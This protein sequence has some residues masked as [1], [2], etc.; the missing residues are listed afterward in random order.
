MQRLIFSTIIFTTIFSSCENNPTGETRVFSDSVME[1]RNTEVARDKIVE[2]E[3]GIQ[4]KGGLK[5]YP[6]TT[7][8]EF[9]DA[10]LEQNLPEE[11]TKL[12]PG[13][14][15]FNYDVKNYQL[16]DT[17][18]LPAMCGACSNSS[19][20]QHI[21]L[22]LNNNP[23]IAH[24]T[25]EFTENL[26]AGNYVAL[27]F[28]SRSY[29]ESIKSPDAYTLRQFTVGNPKD[30]GKVDLNAPHLFYSRPKGEYAGKEAE[31]ILLDFYLV[32]TDL[33]NTGKKVRATINGNEFIIDKWQP[34]II[35]GLPAGEAT[36]KLELLQ[37]DGTLVESPFNPVTRTITVKKEQATS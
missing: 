17:T 28:L 10:K 33:Q 3:L 35:E 20:G 8:P 34:Y 5:L 16:Q 32:N 29:H 9:S 26:K 31:K 19:K 13:E 22:I 37:E 21:H 11:G 7:S 2:Q 6:L 15:K 4:E 1:D 36:I 30:T 25:P 12:K 23:Y 24:Y 27:S 14:V 18:G